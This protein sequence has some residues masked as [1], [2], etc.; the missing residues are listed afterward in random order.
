M[1]VFS[2]EGRRALVTGGSRGLGAEIVKLFAEHG[3]HVGYC[4]FGDDDNAQKLEQ[5]MTQLGL[6]V[7]H[8]IC[9]VSDE[10]SVE[11]LGKWA[12]EQLGD[13]D[14]VVNCAGIGGDLKFHELS[15]EAFDRMIAVHLRG[16]F[17]VTR[18]FFQG[19]V[20]RKWGRVINFSSQLAFKGAPGQSHYCAAKGG[21]VGF[22]RALA[23]EGAPHGVTVNAIAPGPV[24]TD[25][26][27]GLSD[28]WRDMKQAQLPIGR[29]GFP[30][31]IAPTAL[32]LAS[33]AGSFYIGQN[34]S[35]NG[36][37]VML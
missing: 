7:R 2:L 30:H 31:E 37:D 33:E 34:L 35:P 23:Y 36:G 8:T 26:L 14:I 29:F 25:M 15:I 19:M 5:Q 10:T 17:L 9:D 18:Q 28:E 13:I 6:Q 22:T 11:S 12:R 21:I 1:S 32:L 3:A 16:T 20:D 24:E 27:M 4:Q